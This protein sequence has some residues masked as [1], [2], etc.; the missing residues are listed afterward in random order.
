MRLRVEATSLAG[1]LCVWL[2]AG[3]LREDGGSDGSLHQNDRLPESLLL[4]PQ[5]GEPGDCLQPEK[6]AAR[7]ELFKHLGQRIFQR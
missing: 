7:L 1:R 4:I 3:L 5:S 6:R 2:P